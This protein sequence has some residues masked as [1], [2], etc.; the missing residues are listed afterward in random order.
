M[1]PTEP[2][3]P[4]HM[5]DAMK[6]YLEHRIEPGSFLLAVLTN[7]LKGAVGR[8]DHINLKHLTNIVSYCYNEI[9]SQAWG[10]P[11]KVEAWLHPEAANA[12]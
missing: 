9:P 5:R 4:E 11:A 10:S 6:M 12:E 7:D 8:A 3:L 2:Y 1:H